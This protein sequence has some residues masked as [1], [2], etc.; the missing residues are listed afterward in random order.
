MDLRLL[1]LTVHLLG[2]AM[3]V[4][5][6][7]ALAFV[8]AARAGERDAAMADRL[9]D[10]AKKIGRVADGGV[11]FVL[12][13]GIAML[14]TNFHG[15]MTQPWMHAKLTAVL[16]LLGAHGFLRAKTKRGGAVPAAI[17]PVVVLLALAIIA[18]VVFKPWAR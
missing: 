14:A 8:L 4:G 3:W 15:Y 2:L 7:L 17:V 10:L 13:G 18:L 16:L 11:T 9:T 6:M 12:A 5:S 1:Y